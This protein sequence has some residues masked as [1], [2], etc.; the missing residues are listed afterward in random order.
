MR[1]IGKLAAI[2]LIPTLGYLFVHF[3]LAGAVL[4]I[5]KAVFWQAGLGFLLALEASYLVALAAC[6]LG[7]PALA[8]RLRDGRR[9]GVRRPLTA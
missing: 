1:R 4:D 3:Y 6:L 2:A 8:L 9:R 7:I 5:P